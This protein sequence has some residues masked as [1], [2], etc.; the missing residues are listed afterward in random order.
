MSITAYSGPLGA[1]GQAP[2]SDY[3]PQAAASFFFAGGMLLDPRPQYTYVPGNDVTGGVYGWQSMPGVG[4]QTMYA[5][6]VTKS[7]TLIAAANN[8]VSG[9][10]MALASA[11]ATGLQ[12][13]VTVPRQDTGVNVTGLLELDPLVMSCT[14]NVTSGSN[15]LTVTAMGTGTGYNILGICPGMVLTDATH[16]SAIPTGTTITGFVSGVGG[17]GTYTM[18][19]NAASSQTGDTVTGKYT[20]FPHATGFGAAG[21][22]RIWNP[23]AMLARTIIV[24]CNNSSGTGGVIAVNGL[25]V[26]GFPMTENITI[27]PGSALTTSGLK[28]FK[29]IKSVTPAFTDATYTY[30]I[31]TTDVI[32]LPIR[33]EKL[34]VGATVDVSIMMNNALITATTGYLAAVTTT[35]TATT[36]DVRGT[37][38]LQTSSNGTLILSVN[39]APLTPALNSIAGLYGVT[40][41]TAW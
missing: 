36:G 9:T 31:G 13:G 16:A 5:V 37:Y 7:A 1:F 17:I 15:I 25:D 10:A 29:Y 12:V 35:A 14:A 19:A 21:T 8:V 38:A 27:T 39:Q 34:Q 26:Y 20:A 3:N 11:N 2:S 23:T 33:S 32:G 22:I 24:T 18:S 40:Q 41:Y 30:A 6:P 28:A 4:I